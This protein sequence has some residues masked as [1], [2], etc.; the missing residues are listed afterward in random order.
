M[1]IKEELD[2][3]IKAITEAK[4]Y[5]RKGHEV[6]VDIST[7]NGLDAIYPDKLID[8][9]L[10]LQDDEE[11]LK[12]KSFPEYLIR[13]DTMDLELA[14]V[15]SE[16]PN[17]SL[18]DFTIEI[19]EGFDEWCDDYW[20]KRRH[21]SEETLPPVTARRKPAW[22]LTNVSWETR[23]VIWLRWA[24]GDTIQATQR[25][26]E[27]NQGEYADAPI[28]PKTIKKVREELDNLPDELAKTLIKEL[29]EIKVFI[30]QK[31]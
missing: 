22:A 28:D 29:P 20:A 13:P 25:F 17:V 10:I 5:T 4:E 24:K 19:L 26:L 12:I 18:G 15:L 30:E 6:R 23:K 21:S 7:D 16:M 2:L 1:K 8:I 11:I 31:G 9:L 3:I 14:E 27:L